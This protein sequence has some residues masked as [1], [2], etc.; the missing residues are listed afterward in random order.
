M[1]FSHSA[2]ADDDQELRRL[3]LTNRRLSRLVE[4]HQKKIEQLNVS[5]A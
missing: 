4:N 5:I 2:K 1:Y 3:E